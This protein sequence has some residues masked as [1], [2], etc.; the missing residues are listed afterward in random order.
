MPYY[1][2]DSGSVYW[3]LGVTTDGR[4]QN[5]VVGT[6]TVVTLVIRDPSS[7]YW[8]LGI[9]TAGRLTATSTGAAATSTIVLADSSSQLWWLSVQ[10]GGRIQMTPVKFEP[11]E[12]GY[13]P[14]IGG[15]F[16][17]IVTVW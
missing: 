9:T 1:L 7:A 2:Q 10:A 5:T 17:S 15:G 14:P 16:D 12:D 6:Q 8:Q 13:M 11:M 4:E 3:Q